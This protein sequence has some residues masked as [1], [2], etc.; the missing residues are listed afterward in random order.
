MAAVYPQTG[1]AFTNGAGKNRIGAALSTNIIIKVGDSPIGAIQNI[2]VNENR[3]IQMIN[4]V[5]T[6]GHV[7]SA[8]RASTEITGNCTRIRF[9]RLRMAEAFS[10]GFVHVHSQRYPFDID[11]IDTWR[12]DGSSQILTVIRQVWIQSISY[13]YTAD[14]FVIS[15]QMSFTAE[16]IESH[17]V[18]SGQNVTSAAEGGGRSLTFF[19]DAIERAADVGSRRGSMDA[20]GLISAFLEDKRF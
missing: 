6:D 8:P 9:D 5:G 13:S 16:A 2:T 19:S 3:A 1:T 15:E 18:Q 11:I 10:R 4:E 12:G 20:P 14:N 7:D 17:M